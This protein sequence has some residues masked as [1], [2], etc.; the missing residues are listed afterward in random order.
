VTVNALAFSMW[1]LGE[2][3]DLTEGPVPSKERL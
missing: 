2:S 3:A 1:R